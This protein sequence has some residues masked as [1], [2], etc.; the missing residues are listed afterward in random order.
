MLLSAVGQLFSYVIQGV[1]AIKEMA[2]FWKK[3]C[4]DIKRKVNIFWVFWI[5]SDNF[6]QGMSWLII[7]SHLCKHNHVFFNNNYQSVNEV[8]YQLFDLPQADEKFEKPE[9]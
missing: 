6:K 4:T 8:L 3:K 5:N 7:N 9:M 2:E 1:L